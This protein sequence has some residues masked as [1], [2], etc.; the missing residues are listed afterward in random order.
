MRGETKRIRKSLLRL[1]SLLAVMGCFYYG[2]F[3]MAYANEWKQAIGPW[4]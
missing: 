2:Y 3:V 1:L 4:K